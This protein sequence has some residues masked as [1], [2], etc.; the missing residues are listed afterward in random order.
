[1][2][3]SEYGQ[4][5]V[6]EKQY[7]ET[8]I[9]FVYSDAI[10]LEVQTSLHR[11]PDY[12]VFLYLLD[13]SGNVSGASVYMTVEETKEVIFALMAELNDQGHSIFPGSGA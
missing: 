8:S 2:I 12:A 11:E 4:E 5:G 6:S 13:E 9:G 3:R 7:R 10:N 1:M